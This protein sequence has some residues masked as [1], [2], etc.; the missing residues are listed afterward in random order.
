MKQSEKLDRTEDRERAKV[1]IH[2]REDFESMRKAGKLG[3]EV[4]D[5]I[6]PHVKAGISTGELDRLCHDFIIS[7]GA[8]PAPLSFERQAEDSN[9]DAYRTL[10]S[11][12]S[13]VTS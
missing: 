9:P 4:L 3:A 5:F 10:E 6:T 7:H 1:K 12:G 8:V 11:L 13:M 2:R